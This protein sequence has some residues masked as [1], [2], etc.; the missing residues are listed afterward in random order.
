MA[1]HITSGPSR[2]EMLAALGVA[3]WSLSGWL[4]ALARA[5]DNPGRKRSCILLWMAGGPSQMDTFDLK[6]GHA[7]GGPFQEIA[8]AV[9][10]VKFSEHL[11]QL[12]KQAR[13]LAVIRSM[14]T[15]EGDHGRA[16]YHLRTGYVQQAPIDY[17]PLGAALAKELGQPDAD[18]PGFISIA[19]GRGAIPAANGGGFLGPR[20][21]PLMV[22][23]ETEAGGERSLKVQDV[24]PPPGVRPA[25]ADARI[26][27]LDGLDRAFVARHPDPGPRSQQAAFEG[28]V[29]LMKPAVAR[30]FDLDEEKKELRDQYGR[31]LFGQGCL[32][33]R[34]LIERGVPFVEVA[35]GGWDT[36]VGNFDAV[37][38]LSGV[39]DPAW[40]TLL[41]DLGQ[42]GLLDTTLVVWMGEFGRTPQV[43]G[44]AGRDHFPVAWTTVLAGGGIKGGQV[45][46]RTSKDGTAVEDR[47]VPVPDF[48]ATVCKALGVDPT[49][50]NISNV[51]RPIRV[52][53]AGAKPVAEVL[54]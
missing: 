17:P 18:L 52:A 40:A 38:R 47:P 29:R 41:A 15:K 19:P 2:R 25:R 11:P 3:G 10:G 49:T 50:Q 46:G 13:R 42:R 4:G 33:A 12:A 30:A 14:S 48:M 43:N 35:L 32:L 36:H 53:D 22:G 31:S 5:A 39:L 26:A 51:G 28:T 21:A 45:V 54:A 27:L 7:N 34:R 9:P 44:Q 23:S 24:S 16:T 8:S 20:Y 6:P 1:T 37:R